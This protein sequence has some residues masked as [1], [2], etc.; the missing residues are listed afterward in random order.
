MEYR[1]LGSSGLV[2]SAVGFGAWGIGGTPPGSNAYGPTDD[3]ASLNALAR[4]FD[5]GITF[6]DTAAL[7]GSGHSEELI[8]AAFAGKRSQVVLA[9]KVGFLDQAGSSDFSPEHLRASLVASLDRLKTDYLDLF[10]LHD[11]PFALLREKPE[12]METLQGLCRAGQVRAIGISARSPQ[13][14]LAIIRHFPVATVQTN[15]SMTDQRVVEIGLLPVCRE[16][17]V[18]LIGRTPLCFGFLTGGYSAQSAFHP[19]DHRSG[20]SSSQLEAWARAPA[21][22]SPVL[23]RHAP[24][25]KAQLALRYC[26][27]YPE[28][29]TVIPGMLTC[30]HVDENARAGELS[31]LEPGELAEIE[32]LYRST[33]FFVPNARVVTG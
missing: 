2:V 4:A 1:K 3:R 25:T 15:F 22:F 20:W 24:L 30:E 8:G 5:R 11:P 13:E 28:V 17:G 32:A 6:Y 19:Q 9:S 29:S 21:V 33:S 10:Q 14:A 16:R 23:D 7:Y 12:I 27:S 18:G 31:P 26:L